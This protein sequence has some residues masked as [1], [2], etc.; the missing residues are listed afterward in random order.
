MRTPKV[1]ERYYGRSR[2]RGSLGLGP[3]ALAGLLIAGC[4]SGAAKDAIE[5]RAQSTPMATEAQTTV[6]VD[7]GELPTTIEVP[8]L[9]LP[10][11]SPPTLGDGFEATTAYGEGVVGVEL[12]AS[13]V[14]LDCLSG[15]VIAVEPGDTLTSIA[16]GVNPGMSPSSVGNLVAP[17]TAVHNSI[18]DPDVIS[19]GDT[20][21]TLT[22]CIATFYRGD[23]SV[24]QFGLSDPE[25]V[26]QWI[27]DNNRQD[28]YSTVALDSGSPVDK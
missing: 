23:G 5:P 13:S 4:G 19:V 14:E 12:I 18:L 22:F 7:S 28:G 16:Q 2:C 17:A 27:P 21:K 6:T 20:V 9:P 11:D 26:N 8:A 25:R 1:H 3:L 24:T 15:P 10:G